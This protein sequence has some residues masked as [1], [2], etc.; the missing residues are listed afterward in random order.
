MARFVIARP[1]RLLGW[2]TTLL[3][4]CCLVVMAAV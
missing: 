4:G 2:L 3:M 1:L